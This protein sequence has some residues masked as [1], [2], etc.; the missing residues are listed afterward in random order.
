[1]LVFNMHDH[2]LDQFIDFLRKHPQFRIIEDSSK[3]DSKVIDACREAGADILL[4]GIS[5]VKG[6]ADSRMKLIEHMR[7]AMPDCKIVLYADTEMSASNALTVKHL[8][9]Y[10]YVDE[11]F[12]P[13]CS[14][15][16]MVLKLETLWSYKELRDRQEHKN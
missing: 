3:Q 6:A 12:F 7:E 9:G 14:F 4:I 13:S 8:Y 16:Y 5:S 10:R 1:M 11:F 2:T 15:E